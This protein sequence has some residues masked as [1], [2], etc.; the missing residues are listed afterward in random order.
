MY[1]RSP[2]TQFSNEF[3]VILCEMYL[4]PGCPCVNYDNG[5]LFAVESIFKGSN[6]ASFEL[7]YCTGRMWIEGAEKA[8]L[9]ACEAFFHL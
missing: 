4:D 2:L 5:R 6:D 1:T 8:F 7:S 9:C 3:T